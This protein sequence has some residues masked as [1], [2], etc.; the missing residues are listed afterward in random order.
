M[1]PPS[2]RVMINVKE[3]ILR[4]MFFVFRWWRR[5]DFGNH[6]S[7]PV[8]FNLFCSRTPSY[9]FSSTLY[10]QNC[11][12]IIQ[13]FFFFNRLHNPWCVLASLTTVLQAS[14]SDIPIGPSNEGCC[15]C[16]ITI[17]VLRR[18]VVSLTPNPQ[19]G[20]PGYFSLSGL[21]PY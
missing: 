2:P 8:V 12:C 21:Y 11:W 13:V 19:P 10:L 9:N 18:E 20:G 17:Y 5:K 1:R 3:C 16:L 6:C 7:R 15:V 14:L 4:E